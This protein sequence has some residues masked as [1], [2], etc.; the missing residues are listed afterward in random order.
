MN[1]KDFVYIYNIEKYSDKILTEK[2][3]KNGAI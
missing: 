1:K 2:A 3:E